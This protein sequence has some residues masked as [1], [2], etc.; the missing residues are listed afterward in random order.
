M[1][2]QKMESRTAKVDIIGIG[3]PATAKAGSETRTVKNFNGTYIRSETPKWVDSMIH[4]FRTAD[5]Q[6]ILGVWGSAAIDRTMP[7]IPSGTYCELEYL[8][9]TPL[10]SG[11]VM[12][13]IDIRVPQ[14]TKTLVPAQEAF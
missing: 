11:Q 13:N 4:Y 5:T 12:K 7:T 9:T 6:A 3:D 8:G 10:K 2:T 1:T 14:G